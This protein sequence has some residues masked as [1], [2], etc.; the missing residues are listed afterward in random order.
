MTNEHA[1]SPHPGCRYD[2]KDI[3]KMPLDLATDKPSSQ[4]RAESDE[5][6]R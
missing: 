4:W 3:F 2:P 5:C 6:K 1:K